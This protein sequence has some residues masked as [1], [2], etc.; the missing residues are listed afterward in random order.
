[1]NDIQVSIRKAGAGRAVSPGQ[2]A[3][4]AGDKITFTAAHDAASI[5][6]FSSDTAALLSAAGHV[7]LAGGASVSFTVGT[8]QPLDYI[9][10]VQAHGWPV[11]PSIPAGHS[12]QTPRLILRD[13]GGKDFP[14]PPDPPVNTGTDGN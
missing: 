13:A 5:L 14:D 10:V 7:D 11:P 2:S 1:M 3:L 6:C 9:A 8:P 4:A 12:S